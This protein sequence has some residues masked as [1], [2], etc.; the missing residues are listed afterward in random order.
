MELC[1]FED[2][3][4]YSNKLTDIIDTAVSTKNLYLFGDDYNV[5]RLFNYNEIIAWPINILFEA[6]T[7]PTKIAVIQY[8]SNKDKIN[9]TFIHNMTLFAIKYFQIQKSEDIFDEFMTYIPKIADRVFIKV[10]ETQCFH[11]NYDLKFIEF[12]LNKIDKFSPVELITYRHIFDICLSEK[13]YE[14]VKLFIT[15]IGVL[16]PY[17]NSHIAL[18]IMMRVK[19]SVFQTTM[20]LESLEFIKWLVKITPSKMI[21]FEIKKDIIRLLFQ[22]LSVTKNEDKN[23]DINDTMTRIYSCI[24]NYPD[25]DASETRSFSDDDMLR[26]TNSEILNLNVA[27][28]NEKTKNYDDFHIEHANIWTFIPIYIRDDIMTNKWTDEISRYVSYKK[29]REITKYYIIVCAM[30]YDKKVIFDNLIKCIYPLVGCQK[31]FKIYII[32]YSKLPHIKKYLNSLIKNGLISPDKELLDFAI[33]NQNTEIIKELL[34]FRCVMDYVTANN[35]IS[36]LSDIYL[37]NFILSEINITNEIF[38]KIKN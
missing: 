36:I 18:E 21:N 37:R 38:E 26:F 14:I 11:P 8:F 35:A 1:G 25:D 16:I 15:L 23:D 28:I 10:L 27:S 22:D 33:I 17:I 20:D 32:K 29:T 4:M 19:H 24:E 30:L 2:E 6:S 12:L 5:K 34:K 13:K 7:L 3:E 9:D 31:L